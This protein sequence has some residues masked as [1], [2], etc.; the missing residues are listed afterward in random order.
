[1]R[2]AGMLLAKT[3][4][5]DP[6]DAALVLTA[7]DADHRVFYSMSPLLIFHI[8]TASI[9]LPGGVAA[10]S[11]RKG[12][13]GHRCGGTVFVIGMVCMTASA[14]PLGLLKTQTLNALMGAL[15]CYLVA[16]GWVAGRR[17]GLQ[18][19]RMVNAALGLV[20]LAVGVLM[21]RFGVEALDSPTHLKDGEDASGYFFFG[22]IAI[23]SAA[24]DL[25]LLIAGIGNKHRIARHLWRM[26]F[27]LAIGIISVTPRLNRLAGHPVQSDALLVA[28][29]FLV[30]LFMVFWLWRVL[31]SKRGNRILDSV[32]V[33]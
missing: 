10:M 2:E 33:R 15:T 13:R 24:L 28:P 22:A 26:N 21:V 9:A 25:R 27:A 1:M 3:H 5:T 30:L 23:L 31:A 11:L 17:D 16:S 18:S 14:I 4:I 32:P 20:A 29:T 7:Q 12:S 6:V 8:A 19:A